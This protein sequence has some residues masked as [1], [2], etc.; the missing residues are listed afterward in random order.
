MLKDILFIIGAGLWL[1]AARSWIFINAVRNYL[2]SKDRGG[3]EK[4]S[5]TI[6]LRH[7]DHRLD[8]FLYTLGDGGGDCK[9]RK[10]VETT[11]HG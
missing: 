7:V 6:L 5:E 3:T 9:K 11:N 2:R 8:A 1:V 10:R 4:K